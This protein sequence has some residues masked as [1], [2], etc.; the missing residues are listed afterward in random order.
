MLYASKNEWGTAHELNDGD[1]KIEKFKLTFDPPKS[2]LIESN[3]A[4]DK[5]DPVP[6]PRALKIYTPWRLSHL[7]NYS[8]NW[9]M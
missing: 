2:S 6:P 8:D 7:S 3:N 1:G 4:A 9:F 5:P